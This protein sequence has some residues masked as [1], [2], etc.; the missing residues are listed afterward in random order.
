M[1]FFVLNIGYKYDNLSSDELTNAQ[2]EQ[3]AHTHT[4]D[5]S[6]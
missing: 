1:I 2:Y 5:V 3:C 4:Y 6:V